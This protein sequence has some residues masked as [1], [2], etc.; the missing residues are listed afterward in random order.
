MTVTKQQCIEMTYSTK[1]QRIQKPDAV[2]VKKMKYI[3]IYMCVTYLKWW[4]IGCIT[5][6]HISKNNSKKTTTTV[7]FMAIFLPITSITMSDII[8]GSVQ[9]TDLHFFPIACIDAS[10]L[11]R[12]YKISITHHNSSNQHTAGKTDLPIPLCKGVIFS[13]TMR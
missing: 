4:S 13:K 1:Y 11:P 3:Y 5:S 10:K 9:T 12:I 8:G 7:N 6:K 2:C